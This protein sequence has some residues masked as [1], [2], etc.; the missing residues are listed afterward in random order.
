MHLWPRPEQLPAWYPGRT[1]G[2]PRHSYHRARIARLILLLGLVLSTSA[3]A[4]VAHA[5]PRSGKRMQAV[6]S[7]GYQLQG[8]QDR[9]LSAHKLAKSEFDLLVIDYSDGAAP[10][11][12]KDIEAIQKKPDG[13]RRIVLAYL[14]IGEAEDYRFYWKKKWKKRK[15]AFLARANEDWGG[16]FKVR[17]WMPEWQK[18]IFGTP[19]STDSYLD[20]IIDAGFDGVYLDIID[21]YEYFGP[22]GEEPERPTAAEDMCKFVAR[23]AKHA[24]VDR[25]KKGFLLVPQNGATILDELPERMAKAYLKTVDGI[26]AEDTFFFG[27]SD[28]NNPLDPQ[29]E[30][31]DALVRFRKAGLPVFAVDYLTK[32]K[33]AATFVRMAKKKGFIP[34]VGH[35]ELDRLQKQP[36]TTK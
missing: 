22:D 33:A 30:T 35:R 4:C 34:Y 19:S 5:Q 16:N 18:L 15:P 29:T 1:L 27:E 7:W 3:I 25:K 20:R 24:R 9:E 8:R 13:S 2:G 6:R 10:W 14:S 17:Y 23:L 11:S 26:G 12:R 28:H 31:I 36:G 32:A 21:A